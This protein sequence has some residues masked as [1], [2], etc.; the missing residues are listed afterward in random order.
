[1]LLT[2]SVYCQETGTYQAD[3][4]YKSN[5]IKLRKWYRGTN[6]K[7]GTTMYYDKEG[8]LSKYEIEMNMGAS[9][10]TTHYIYNNTGKLIS[11]V[12]STVNSKPDKREIKRLKKMGINPNLLM[13][14]LPP[15]DLP[16]LEVSSYELEYDGEQLVKRSKYN[17]NGS[18][19]IVDYFENKGKIQKRDW[20]RNGK[21]YSNTVTEY[22]DKFHKEKFY[23]W[24]IDIN[25]SK[26]TWNYSFKYQ[27]D[28]QGN[29]I[30]ITRFD[31]EEEKETVIYVYN[32]KGLLTQTYGQHPEF[33]EYEYFE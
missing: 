26:H 14:L 8:R 30:S 7:G 16:Q 31:G 13:K 25:G 2:V 5:N 18:L 24:E 3:S 20:Y 9:L 1:M 33:F 22:L 28:E 6:K 27:F 11:M 32:S 29:V 23:G 17:P 12:D 19:D 21:L 10:R 15:N 4:V